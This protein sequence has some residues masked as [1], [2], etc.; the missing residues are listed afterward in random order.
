[1]YD[2]SGGGVILSYSCETYLDY[3]YDD[4]SLEAFHPIKA[5]KER[6]RK[7]CTTLYR[8]SMN[9]YNKHKAKH[10]KVASVFKRF[11]DF[12][13]KHSTLVDHMSTEEQFKK[14][15]DALQEKAE[16]L[17]SAEEKFKKRSDALQEKAEKLHSEMKETSHQLDNSIDESEKLVYKDFKRKYPNST[18]SEAEFRKSMRNALKY[19][20]S[21]DK[22]L[23]DKND[24]DEFFSDITKREADI[25]KRRAKTLNDMK[26]IAAR[27]KKYGD[28]IHRY[29]KGEISFKE[30]QKNLDSI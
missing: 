24:I 29:K 1:M 10:P 19:E 14:E 13:K 15:S 28:Q 5:I 30:L 7:I 4:I 11:A 21:D 9:M 2:E 25:D 8:K 27:S 22:A 23:K 12:F 26:E 6:L 20:V 3:S 17:L 16:E 18:I